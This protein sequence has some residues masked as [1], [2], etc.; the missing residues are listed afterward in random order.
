[1]IEL[2][3]MNLLTVVRQET[4]GMYLNLK[5]GDPLDQVLL[6]NAYIEEGLKIG[7]EIEVFVYLDNEERITAT[8]LKPKLLINQF[9][10]LAADQVNTA[11]AF[12]DMGIV[13][14]LLVPY[15][16]Q[17]VPMEEG[18]S[19]VVYMYLDDKTGRLVATSKVNRYL[20]NDDVTLEIG[21]EVDLIVMHSSELGRNVII[22]NKYHGLIFNSDVNQAL[23]V[24]QSLTGFVKKVRQ[25][26]KIDVILQQEGIGSIEPNAQKVIDILAKNDGFLALNDKSD[27]E[28]ISKKISMSKKSFKKAIGNLYKSRKIT[29]SEEGI[30][31][32]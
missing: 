12:M 28:L 14:Q 1:M 18:R 24:G 25:D 19:Y 13:K 32:V 7:D 27:P 15:K 16:E 23:K 5:T 9:A 4:Q 6:P 8:T 26:G 29:I 30:K 10:N 17:A 3:K 21:N 2:G 11:G 20:S 22:N 31:L